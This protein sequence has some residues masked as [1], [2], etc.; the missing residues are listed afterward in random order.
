MKWYWHLPPS[1]TCFKVSLHSMLFCSGCN[2]SQASS[3]LPGWRVCV[4]WLEYIQALD[5]QLLL[6]ITAL[7]CECWKN[8]PMSYFSTPFFNVRRIFFSLNQNKR[9]FLQFLVFLQTLSVYPSG[10]PLAFTIWN[11]RVGH[12]DL[13]IYIYQI[14]FQPFFR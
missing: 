3:S 4:P 5:T 12:E 6:Q 9:F 14:Y 13:H 2:T 8:S 1:W 7:H 11:G 10:K